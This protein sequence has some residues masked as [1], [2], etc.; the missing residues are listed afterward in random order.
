MLTKSELAVQ[1][2]LADKEV[3]LGEFTLRCIRARDLN[4]VTCIAHR[5]YRP[6]DFTVTPQE[7]LF[8][9][10]FNHEKVLVKDMDLLTLR[11]HREELAHIAFEARARLTAV[12]DE[13]KQRKTKAKGDRPEGFARNLETDEIS[14]NAIN[15][16]KTRQSKLT[17]QE[18]LL[19]GLEKLGISA[20]DAGK[21]LSA[22]NM[23]RQL[24][25]KG[26]GEATVESVTK[27]FP[28]GSN[29]VRMIALKMGESSEC[30]ECKEPIN[31][32]VSGTVNCPQC[33]SAFVINRT[34]RPV[35]NPFA[36]KEA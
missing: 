14:S 5:C 32:D 17:K 34:N 11:A 9:Q 21:I 25:S 16:I 26:N 35:V 3:E 18:K 31:A 10:L 1:L 20:G 28:K 12:D 29:G 2:Y 33:S 7:E 4:R 13:E 15:T 8:S 19:A 6:G 36:K 24:Q 23:L 22:G 27:T 30:P